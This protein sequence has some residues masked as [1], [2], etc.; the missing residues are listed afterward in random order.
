MLNKQKQ[1]PIP[2]DLNRNTQIRSTEFLSEVDANHL[3]QW[4][5]Q[6]FPIEGEALVRSG[7]KWHLTAFIGGGRPITHIGYADFEVCFNRNDR[8]PV[9]G[10]ADVVVRPEH[11]GKHLPAKLFDYLHDSDHAN[12]QSELFVLFCPLRLESY[13]EKH[14][15]RKFVGGYTFMQGDENSHSDNFILMYRGRDLS[16]VKTIQIQCEPW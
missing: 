4:R 14:G 13:Y 3:F 16:A 8:Q 9:V 11:Q 1:A 12:S 2:T 7:I 6:V 10:V 15:Y 5:K